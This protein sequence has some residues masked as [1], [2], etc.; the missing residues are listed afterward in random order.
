MFLS[1]QIFCNIH[2]RTR[3]NICVC[4]NHFNSKSFD[5]SVGV[6]S[7]PLITLPHLFNAFSG[8][9]STGITSSVTKPSNYASLLF[10]FWSPGIFLIGTLSASFLIRLSF[11]LIFG[12]ALSISY[13]TNNWKQD[14]RVCCKHVPQRWGGAVLRE[15]W[16]WNCDAGK[17]TISLD[18]IMGSC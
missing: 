17:M 6:H 10:C 9:L 18:N 3:V 16:N 4:Q 14:C 8:F 12:F 7:L 2:F 5:F 11:L 15:R 13:T 1:I